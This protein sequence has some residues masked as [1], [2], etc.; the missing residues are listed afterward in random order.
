[1]SPE[2]PNDVLPL[3]LRLSKEASSRVARGLFVKVELPRPIA[4]P[5]QGTTTSVVVGRVEGA[6]RVYANLCRH[7]AIPLDARG[8]TRLGVMNEA[9]TQLLC[10]SH[11]AVYDLEDGRCSYGPCEG[12]ALYMFRVEEIHPG[13]ALELVISRDSPR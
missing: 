4:V 7:Q 3:T 12:L 9:G 11:G 1:M 6:L 2:A 8:G 10:D 13:P 5:A